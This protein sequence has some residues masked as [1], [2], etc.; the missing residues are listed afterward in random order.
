LTLKS[1]K[2]F[3]AGQVKCIFINPPYNTQSAFSH[4]DDRLEHSQ[5]LSTTYPRI[6][7]LRELLSEDGIGS[8]NRIAL[9]F[10]N[11]RIYGRG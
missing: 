6:V 11:M 1:L 5:W 9:H 3:Y 8:I 10:S 7:L 2:P 4:Y